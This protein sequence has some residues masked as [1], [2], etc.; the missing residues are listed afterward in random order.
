VAV[1]LGLL[2]ALAYGTGDFF[3]GLAAKRARTTAVVIGSFG[4]AVLA[5]AVV[6]VGWFVLGD[7]PTPTSADLRLGAAAGVLGPVSLGLL[8]HGLATGRMSVVAPITAVV[9][10][11]VPLIWGL[12][13]GERP[14]PVALIGVVAALVA[15]V[16]ISA[17]PPHEDH[18]ADAPVLPIRTVVPPAVASGLGFGIIYVL[19]GNTSPDAGLWPLVVARP[20]AVA[21]L[22]S[23]VLFGTRRPGVAVA[24]ALI[25][26]GAWPVVAAAGV[27]DVTASGFYLAGI[28]TGLL[29]IVAVLSSLYPAATVLLARVV[30]GERL[31]R[32]QI[33]GLGL[34]AL[35]VGA[36]AGA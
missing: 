7:P 8:Y 9:A 18:P 10:A 36:M 33:A 29:S 15:V 24:P 1:V 34:A 26:T 6:H 2:V 20:I 5:L 23:V 11:I 13:A 35:G 28:N 22:V 25:P 27:L 31:H 32:A 19:L 16:L 30:L 12:A 14:S 3:G 21:L 4:V 17:A